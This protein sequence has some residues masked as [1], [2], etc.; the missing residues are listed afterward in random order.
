M[1]AELRAQHAS[2]LGGVAKKNAAQVALTGAMGI[3]NKSPI[4]K[5]IAEVTKLAPSTITTLVCAAALA[6]APTSW[7]TVREGAAVVGVPAANASSYELGGRIA[8]V[9]FDDSAAAPAA[10]TAAAAPESAPAAPSADK[11]AEPAKG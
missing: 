4:G 11:P 8:D 3:A 5:K 6:F 10:G 1:G 7:Q 2:T 9:L